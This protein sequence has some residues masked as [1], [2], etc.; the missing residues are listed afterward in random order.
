MVFPTHADARKDN[1]I[2]E[3]GAFVGFGT[4]LHLDG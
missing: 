2:A 4:A 1:T 3:M